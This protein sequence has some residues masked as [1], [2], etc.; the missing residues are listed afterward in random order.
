MVVWNSFFMPMGEQPP[1]MYPVSG[2]RSLDLH[3]EDGF[4]AYRSGSLFQVQFLCHRNEKDVVFAGL[5]H[6]DQRLE[7]LRR[8]LSQRLCQLYAGVLSVACSQQRWM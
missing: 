5:C 2:S 1:W 6:S 3:M 8:V 7:Y 4:F